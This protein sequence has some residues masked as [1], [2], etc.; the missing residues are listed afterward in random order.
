MAQPPYWDWHV[1]VTSNEPLLFTFKDETGQRLNLTE[2]EVDV[3]FQWP[4]GVLLLT[5]TAGGV[6]KLPQDDALSKGRIRV[7]L[8][9]EQRALLPRE[10]PA[11]HEIR[12]IKAGEVRTALRGAAVAWKWTE[13]PDV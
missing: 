6:Q 3:R 8:S 13:G 7:D 11:R 2:Y 9:L 1:W 4:G 5:T 12:L 10:M